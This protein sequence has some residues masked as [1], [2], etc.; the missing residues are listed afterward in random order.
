MEADLSV[1]TGAG[2]RIGDLP[3]VAKVASESTAKILHPLMPALNRAGSRSDA[4]CTHF[5]RQV[6]ESLLEEAYF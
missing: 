3:L 1:Q 2:E 5:G 6:N 4:G